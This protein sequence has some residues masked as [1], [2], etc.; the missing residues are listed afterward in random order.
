MGNGLSADIFSDST[1]K[2][3]TVVIRRHEKGISRVVFKKTG[4]RSEYAAETSMEAAWKR[5]GGEKP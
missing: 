5:L 1:G 4:L 3:W 2:K